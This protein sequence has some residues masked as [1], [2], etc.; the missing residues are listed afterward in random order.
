ME[1]MVTLSTVLDSHGW[2]GHATLDEMHMLP[3]DYVRG[4][5]PADISIVQVADD[6]AQLCLTTRPEVVIAK[7][8]TYIDNYDSDDSDA[9]DGDS[10]SGSGNGNDP[11]YEIWVH[12]TP[13]AEWLPS[14]AVAIPGCFNPSV[15]YAF[16]STHEA[17]AARTKLVQIG[18]RV[19]MPCNAF[20]D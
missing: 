20:A 5:A 17:T 11:V 7:L 3:V 10:G 14:S 12:P 1:R 16:R 19:S 4:D 2:G 6:R 18:Y 9:F 15:G 13:A 8:R